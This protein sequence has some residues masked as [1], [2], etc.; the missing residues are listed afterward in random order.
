MGPEHGVQRYLESEIWATANVECENKQHQGIRY[1]C[2][3]LQQI[4]KTAA[5]L[6]EVD[7]L[8]ASPELW[9]DLGGEAPSS[10]YFSTKPDQY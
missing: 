3:L 8:V 2:M 6:Q 4:A 9:D 10:S 7:F 1:H 5:I